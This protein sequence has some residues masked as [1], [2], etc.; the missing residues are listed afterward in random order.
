[1][2]H[3]RREL[4][5]KYFPVVGDKLSRSAFGVNKSLRLQLGI[6]ARYGV[7]IDLQPDGKFAY[8]GKLCARAVHPAE[9]QPLDVIGYLRVNGLICLKFHIYLIVL[10]D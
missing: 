8:G 3:I 6:S 1:M 4:V 5:F 9:N 7:G 10:L 2:P